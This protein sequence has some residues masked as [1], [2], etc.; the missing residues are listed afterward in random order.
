M[1][2][3][4]FWGPHPLENE[5]AIQWA[6]DNFLENTLANISKTLNSPKKKQ[7]LAEIRVAAFLL[8]KLSLWFNGLYELKPLVTLSIQ[9][10][11]EFIGD[12]SVLKNY[13][14][15]IALK[16]QIKDLKKVEKE[17]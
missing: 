7:N 9:K 13:E 10:L 16:D 3:S 14:F 8:Q 15:A 5:Y 17:L 11:T 6:K 2:E 4:K 1:N 12:E